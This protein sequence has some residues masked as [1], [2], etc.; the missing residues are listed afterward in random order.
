MRASDRLVLPGLIG[1]GAGAALTAG[2]VWLTA[3]GTVPRVV[4][5]GWGTWALLGFVLLLSLAEMPMMVF[6]LR[7]MAGG[8][9]TRSA[10]R[11]ARLASAAFVFFAAFYA[12]PFTALTGHVAAG[13]ALAALCLA[14][15]ACVLL[16]VPGSGATSQISDI[17]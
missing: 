4:P 5:P 15:L 12:A 8:T 3:G 1:L 7:R 17:T 16:I 2:A 6:A 13:V 10:P 14:R 11:I 9:P